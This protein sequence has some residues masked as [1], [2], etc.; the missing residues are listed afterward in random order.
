MTITIDLP[1]ELVSR[2]AA[3]LPEADRTTFAVSASAD[4]LTLRQQDQY[5]RISA[6]LRPEL[7]PEAE[8]ERDSAECIAIVEAELEDIEDRGKLL[9]LEEARRQ[10]D[11]QKLVRLHMVNSMR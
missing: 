4:A 8:H 2:L 1:E 9:S 3:I 10:W 7:D 6:A 5:A 11:A